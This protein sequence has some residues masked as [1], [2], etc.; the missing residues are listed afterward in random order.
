MKTGSRTSCIRL[1]SPG[2]RRAVL[3]A[4]CCGVRPVRDPFPVVLHVRQLGQRIQL[5]T[6][7]S[8]GSLHPVV[9]VVGAGVL[10]SVS[11]S[12]HQ[13]GDPVGLGTGIFDS[14]RSTLLHLC[15]H[16]MKETSR[17]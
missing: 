6:L 10:V 17:R 11:G 14:K 13:A 4:R 2:E 9:N 8:I 5:C 16:A 12:H 1:P 7:L 15:S 3:Y